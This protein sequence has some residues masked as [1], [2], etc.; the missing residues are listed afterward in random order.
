MILDELTEYSP[1][2][3]TARTIA[4]ATSFIE[5]SSSSP[6]EEATHFQLK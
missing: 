2:N 3:P 5:T 4:S 6:T 1:V